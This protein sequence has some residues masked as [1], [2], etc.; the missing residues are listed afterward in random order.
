MPLDSTTLDP[1]LAQA[2]RGP[3]IGS[4][5]K[6]TGAATVRHADGSTEPLAVGAPLYRDDEVSTA[7]GGAL[8]LVF[9]DRSTCSL[10]SNGKLVLDEMVYD[11]QTGTSSFEVVQGAFSFV[12]GQIAK[13]GPDKMQI[14]TPVMTIGIRGTTLAGLADP[15]GN[16][17]E[18]TLLPDADGNVGQ[19][20]VSTAGATIVLTRIGDH[21]FV[22]EGSGQLVTSILDLQQVIE[23]YGEALDARPPAPA[24]DI[25]PPPDETGDA[26][27]DQPEET[28]Q[29]DTGLEQEAAE[30][31]L[32]L[33]DEELALL[34]Q[35]LDLVE[36]DLGFEDVID[37]YDFLG[38]D[39]FGLEFEDWGWLFLAVFLD[40]DFWYFGEDD[41]E[42]YGD[43]DDGYSAEYGDIFFGSTDADDLVG[44]DYDDEFIF[45]AGEWDPVNDSVD[46]GAGWDSLELELANGTFDDSQL[47]NVWG[48][49][50]LDVTGSN[51]GVV[52]SLG[53]D[54]DA[55]GI[56]V[57][58][59]RDH[60]SGGVD[61]YTNEMS[62]DVTLYGSDGNDRLD[63][64]SGDDDLYGGDGN[65]FLLGKGGS[66]YVDGGA[67][68]DEVRADMDAVTDYY[69][70][71]MG[72]NGEVRDRLSYVDATSAITVTL[73][74]SYSSGGL[75]Y[76]S[77]NVTGFGTDYFDE[78]G[79]IQGGSGNDL[80]KISDVM[81]FSSGS[82]MHFWG[83]NGSDT[84]AFNNGADSNI[85]LRGSGAFSGIESLDIRGGT[86]VSNTVWINNEFVQGAS[87][88][89]DL[90]IVGD[91]NDDLVLDDADWQDGHDWAYSHDSGGYSI[92]TYGTTGIQVQ[93]QS[94][95]V[96]I[97]SPPVV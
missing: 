8:G 41:E 33:T 27:L 69:Y 83:G 52:L 89:D 81:G 55:K 96:T 12:S 36:V 95:T 37:F 20:V 53:A 1:Q 28:G 34:G 82:G 73:Q 47:A 31:G 16:R 72:D 86:G 7:P 67:G 11:G 58:D 17:N 13:S 56:Q 32:N 23:R 57:V 35:D 70:G 4:V 43:E 76:G 29:L 50:E 92:Y 44:T 68:A 62:N 2:G 38:F 65:D 14:K 91:G 10:G 80:M 60:L 77:G 21:A 19:I 84:V 9:A 88:S 90:I 78:F 25:L 18:I 48:I 26:P 75:W 42:F 49:E 74:D 6:L 79:V 40:E 94:A 54:A 63:A 15:T 5:Q 46:G 85:D 71:G 61:V 39:D 45:A 22:D 87:Y 30:E 97:Q 59:C 66:D 64:G 93:T 51:P 3:A 24:E